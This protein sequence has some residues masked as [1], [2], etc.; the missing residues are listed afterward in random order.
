MVVPAEENLA[1]GHTISLCQ[2][3]FEGMCIL[4]C[5]AVTMQGRYMN[6]PNRVSIK[7]CCRLPQTSI[8]SHCRQ[9][10][11]SLSGELCMM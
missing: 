4:G 1:A 2:G 9:N 7:N 10:G 5:L 11:G 3:G 6:T 8:G